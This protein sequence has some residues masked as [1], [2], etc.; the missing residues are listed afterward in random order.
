MEDRIKLPLSFDASRLKQDLHGLEQGEWIDHFV[1]QNYSGS[2]SVIPLRAPRT[3]KHPVMMIGS[4]PTCDDFVD[5]PFLERSP[6]LKAVLAQIECPL[7]AVR[8]MKLAVGS[9]IKEHRDHE[10]AYEDGHIRMHIPVV[11]NPEV[12]FY[13]NDRRVVMGEGECWYLRLSDP[14]RVANRGRTDRVHLVIDA[15]VNAWVTEIFARGTAA[16]R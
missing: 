15:R 4:D 11:T 16:L 12:E 10:L 1:K 14:H 2:W 3:A 13:L 8:L 9:D 7:D 5:T 6:Y